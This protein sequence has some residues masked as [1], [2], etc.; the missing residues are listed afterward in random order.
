[1][2]SGL[3][4]AHKALTGISIG[5]AFGESFFGAT[6]RMKAAIAERQLPETSWQFTDDTIMAIPIYESLQRFDGVDQEYIVQRFLE[7]Y[8]HDPERGYGPSMHHFFR[9]VEEGANW[10]DIAAGKFEGMGSMGNGGAMRS[11]LIGACF[12]N[13]MDRVASEAELA[14]MVTHTN[15]EAVCGSIAVAKAC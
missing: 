14:C 11:A 13:D 8:Q 7:N 12:S 1:M 6:S 2:Q 15:V 3:A 4:A 5:D 9:A 10:K